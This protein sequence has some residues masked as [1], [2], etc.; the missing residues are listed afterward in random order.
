MSATASTSLVGK[1]KVEEENVSDVWEAVSMGHAATVP[2]AEAVVA[3]ASEAAALAAAASMAGDRHQ[4]GA[5]LYIPK[6]LLEI[7]YSHID[8]CSVEC[9]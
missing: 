4:L 5:L 3:A 6:N 2:K 8:A 9:L 1:E 7:P